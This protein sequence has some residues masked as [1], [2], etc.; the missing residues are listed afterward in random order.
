[1]SDDEKKKPPRSL[2]S[3]IF[4]SVILAGGWVLGTVVAHELWHLRWIW[5]ALLAPIAILVLWAMIQGA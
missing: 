4:W 1:M 3:M 5:C 2:A